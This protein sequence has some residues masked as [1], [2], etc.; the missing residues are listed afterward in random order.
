MDSMWKHPVTGSLPSWEAPRP[1]RTAWSTSHAPRGDARVL[2]SPSPIPVGRCRSRCT[3]MAPGSMHLSKCPLPACEDP[4][5]SSSLPGRI[6]A[7]MSG[8]ASLAVRCLRVI[9]SN[10]CRVCTCT[11]RRRGTPAAD[12]ARCKCTAESRRRRFVHW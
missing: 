4:L 3:L 8:E 12:A 11:H 2:P 5:W 7:V 6:K 10:A 9:V 1:K